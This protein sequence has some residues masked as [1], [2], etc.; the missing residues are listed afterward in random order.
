MVF[1]NK[2]VI[3]LVEDNRA[4]E[5]LMTRALEKSGVPHVLVVARDGAE[6]LNYLLGSEPAG[7]PDLVLMDINLPKLSGLE[8]LERLRADA[9]NQKPPVVM[10]SAS[11]TREDVA[12]AYRLGC[13]SYISKGIDFSQFLEMAQLLAR[14]WLVLNV[15]SREECKVP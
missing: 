11:T 15:T 8:V 5:E 13:N 9:R 3:L 12:A 6:A 4:E 10:L 1:V 2:K 14:Y 7:L